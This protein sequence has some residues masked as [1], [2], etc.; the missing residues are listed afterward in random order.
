MSRG[1]NKIFM[2]LGS[3]HNSYV[4]RLKIA[5]EML[6]YNPDKFHIFLQQIIKLTKNGAEFKMSKRSGNSLTIQDMLETIGKDASRWFLVSTTLDTHLNIDVDKVTSKNNDN[7]VYYVQYAHARISQLLEKNKVTCIIV[8]K[9]DLLIK[10]EERELIMQIALYPH[11]IRNVS[12]N[13]E[14]HKL[15]NYLYQLARLYHNYYSNHKVN[16][17]SNQQ[18]SNQRYTLS[19]CV[20]QVI[21]NGLR[22]LGIEPCEKM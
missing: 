5:A 21:N 1:Y 19:F 6:G 8:K 15:C 7:P 10:P 13:Y 22:I 17:A 18:L 14:V 2:I 12:V 9:Y 3:D 11:V 16:D 20:K 4:A